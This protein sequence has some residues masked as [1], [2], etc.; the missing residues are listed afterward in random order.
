MS[1]NQ[2]GCP[3]ANDDE[4][5]SV[6][7]LRIAP[8]GWAHVGEP[9]LLVYIARHY[10]QPPRNPARRKPVMMYEQLLINRQ[11]SCER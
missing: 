7:R 2:P 11:I 4:V 6:S 3:S 5:V 8:L 1:C 10:S 9:L